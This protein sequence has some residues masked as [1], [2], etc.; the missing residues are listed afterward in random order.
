LEE[1]HPPPKVEH[2]YPELGGYTLIIY[3]LYERCYQDIPD[4]D[5]GKTR[6]L[7]YQDE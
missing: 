3:L 2:T 4:F 6:F 5:A 7:Y 1:D